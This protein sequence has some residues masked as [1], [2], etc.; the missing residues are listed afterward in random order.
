MTLEA[1]MHT[2]GL[3]SHISRTVS[4]CDTSSKQGLDVQA[5]VWQYMLTYTEKQ[6]NVE[7]TCLALMM[8]LIMCRLSVLH[9][10]Y[11]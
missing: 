5:A 2:F 4:S 8:M 1:C 10:I 3:P 9:E 7:L 11:A 6:P